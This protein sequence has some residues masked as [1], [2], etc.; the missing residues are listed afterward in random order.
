MVA[1][2]G[3]GNPV[4]TSE[5]VETS[6]INMSSIQPFQFEPERNINEEDS[7]DNSLDG[8]VSQNEERR[9][10]ARV[11]QNRWCKCGNCVSMVSEK[12]SVCCRELQFL[13]ADVHGKYCVIKLISI[14]D[15]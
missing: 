4:E 15:N 1:L 10:E 14:S 2:A 3:F 13:S 9:D 6:D 11:G 5:L 8:N 7:T 12:E